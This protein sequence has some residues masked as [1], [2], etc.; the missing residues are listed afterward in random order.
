MAYLSVTARKKASTWGRQFD[1]VLR[2]AEINGRLP[3]AGDDRRLYSWLEMQQGMYEIGELNVVQSKKVAS[4][5][6]RY[7]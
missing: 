4:L 6:R 7:E 3:G 2:W 1:K 5:M